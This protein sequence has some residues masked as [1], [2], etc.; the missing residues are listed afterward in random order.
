MTKDDNL[1]AENAAEE[2]LRRTN[3]EVHPDEFAIAAVAREE[4]AVILQDAALSPSGRD[5]FM[6]FSDDRQVTLIL[7]SSDLLSILAALGRSRVQRGYRLLT[8]TIELDLAFVGFLALVT[9]ILAAANVPVLALSSFSRDHLLI[10]QT[11]LA[12]ALRALGPHVA[13]LC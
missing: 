5:P 1:A 9:Q 8:F 12:A 4:W 3:V 13:Q 10:R 2:M 6:I 11:D 7:G